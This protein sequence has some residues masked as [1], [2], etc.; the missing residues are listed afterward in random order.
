MASSY[1]ISDLNFHNV[2]VN[3]RRCFMALLHHDLIF[4]RLDDCSPSKCFCWISDTHLV[5]K[6]DKRR[7]IPSSICSLM[8]DA[9]C[10]S[11]MEVEGFVF[12]VLTG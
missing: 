1:R 6:P 3:S 12:I 9:R 2:C 4:G 11:S 7:G 5:M 8:P 10:W